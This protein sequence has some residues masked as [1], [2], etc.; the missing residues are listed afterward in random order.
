MQRPGSTRQSPRFLA[1]SWHWQR[2]SR[3]AVRGW[4]FIGPLR[5]LNT[6]AGQL[7]NEDFTGFDP[8]LRVETSFSTLPF[9]A[10][11]SLLESGAALQ[12]E[13]GSLNASRALAPP[14]PAKR[15]RKAVTLRN[16]EPWLVCSP[17]RDGKLREV[18]DPQRP[19]APQWPRGLFP[20][21]RARQHA[22]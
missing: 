3:L 6:L 21:R 20:P 16:K 9:V 12:T 2:S 15:R 17:L 1:L 19:D 7:T 5:E 14:P 10:L 13:V 8:K 18:P 22:P 11:P 4:S